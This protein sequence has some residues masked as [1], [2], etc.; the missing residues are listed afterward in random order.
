[1]REFYANA[2]PN[3]DE[4]FTWTTRVSGRQVAFD[5]DTIN[6]VLGE[7]FHLGE[8]ERD[9]YHQDLRLHRDTDSISAAL[10]F[11]GKSVELN[12]FGVPMRYHREDMI[13]MA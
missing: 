5:Q 12:P 6:C 13:P 9:A 3:D 7:P 4:P 10:L 11:E 1:M 8:N 2:L